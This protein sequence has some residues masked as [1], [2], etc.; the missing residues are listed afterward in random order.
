[1]ARRPPLGIPAII[2]AMPPLSPREIVEALNPDLLKRLREPLPDDPRGSC[3][4]SIHSFQWL[5]P[6]DGY[7]VTKEDQIVLLKFFAGIDSF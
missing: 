5:D 3:R 6:K 2:P 7:L 1:M 4:S